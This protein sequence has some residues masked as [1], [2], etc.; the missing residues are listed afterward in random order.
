MTLFLTVATLFLKAFQN[1]SLFYFIF[2]I[3]VTIATFI[4][5]ATQYD[6]LYLM[7]FNNA[8][9]SQCDSRY[10]TSFDI[11]QLQL[12]GIIKISRERKSQLRDIL[13]HCILCYVTQSH[14]V[15]LYLAM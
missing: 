4:I 15:T 10:V 1:V 5:I 6:M 8:T 2:F 12:Y 9:L 7:F 11:S 13:S 14:N 3:N